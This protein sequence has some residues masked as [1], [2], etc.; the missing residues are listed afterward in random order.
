MVRV[1]PADHSQLEQTLVAHIIAGDPGLFMIVSGNDQQGTAGSVLTDPLVVQ[2]TDVY[3]NGVGQYPVEFSVLSGGGNV[4]GQLSTTVFTDEQGLARVVYGLGSDGTQRVQ[5]KTAFAS[6]FFTATIT[7]QERR[8]DF[9]N[10]QITVSDSTAFPDGMDRVTIWV[11]IVDTLGDPVPGVT[12][13]LS[14][15]GQ[16]NQLVQPANPTDATGTTS[17]KLSSTVAGTKQITARVMPEGRFLMQSTEVYFASVQTAF[18]KVSGDNQNG[19][20]GQLLPDPF[21]VQVTVGGNPEVD[22]AVLYRVIAGDGHFNG[23]SDYLTR[24]D[25]H[26]K[27]GARLALAESADSVMVRVTA[28]GVEKELIFKARVAPD[29]ELQLEKFAGDNQQVP[30]GQMPDPLMVRVTDENSVAVEG[31]AVRFTAI[32]GGTVP[33]SQPVLTNR[34]GLAECT[35]QVPAQAGE[36]HFNAHMPS[37]DQTVTFLVTV[38]RQNHPPEIVSYEPAQKRLQLQDGH[39]IEFHIQ[40]RD[41]DNDPV[42]YVWSFNDVALS[43]ESSLSLLVNPTLPNQFVIVGTAYDKEDSTHIEWTCSRLLTDIILSKFT[44]RYVEEEGVY[45]E[46]AVDDY[47][48]SRELRIYR[49]DMTTSGPLQQVFGTILSLN[50][51]TFI[52]DRDVLP[53]RQYRYQIDILSSSGDCLDRGEAYVGIELPALADLKPCYPNP[54][55]STVRIHYILPEPGFRR[56]VVYNST[57]SRVRV[58]SQGYAASGTHRLEWNGRDDAGNAVP[59]GVFYIELFVSGQRQ[60]R[61]V[62]LIK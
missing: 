8:I 21:V 6:V 5:A 11:K 59:S 23:N 16:G 49:Q 18:E 14:A 58:L 57:G 9:D 45:L 52:W 22:H 37:S 38:K 42:H 1:Y 10:S 51:P 56:V 34:D 27:A 60:V 33:G 62:V 31:I 26:G 32:D 41:A 4:N 15:T 3:G 2:V 19:I 29:R 55:N 30:Y 25:I 44:S 7:A 12:V 20:A 61:K 48:S 47:V 24:T 40:A 43:N 17:G 35:V 39:Q 28:A 36:Y 46:W 53:G 50:T 13:Q 54:F